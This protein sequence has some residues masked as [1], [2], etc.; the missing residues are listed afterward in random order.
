MV[1]YWPPD[2]EPTGLA[3]I[4][5]LDRDVTFAAITRANRLGVALIIASFLLA[6]LIT[7]LLGMRL[8]RRPFHRLMA[9]AD[10]WRTGDLA[11]RSGMHDVQSESGRLGNAFDAMAAAQANREQALRS[12]L[13]STTDG[14]VVFDRSWRMT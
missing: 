11:A 14:V 1:A 13:E 8:I 6:L 12:A 2:A 3:I 7:G 10:R 9:V 4:V 5:G